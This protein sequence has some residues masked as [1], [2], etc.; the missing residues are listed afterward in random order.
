MF[1]DDPARPLAAAARAAAAGYEAVFAPDHLF[2]PGRPDRPSLEPFSVLAAVAA[3]HPTLRVGTLVT[4]AS[5]RP[6]GLLAK[7]GAALDHLSAG[8]AILGI[9]AGDSTSKAEHGAFGIPFRPA[10]ERVALMEETVEALRALF[11][12]ATWGGGLHVP[13]LLGPL[14]PPGDPEL[15]IG[16]RSEPVLAAAARRADAWN[17]W[18]MDAEGFRAAASTVRALADGRDVAATWGGILLVGEDPSDLDRL[19]SGRASRGLSM[20]LWQGTTDELRTFA[21]HLRDAG[22]DWM[23]VQPVGGD[24]RIELV[25]TSLR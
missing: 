20:D 18:A 21:A 14:L 16:G 15:W 22:A 9:G 8:R 23:I 25:A 1:T 5:I 17:G 19:R 3:R 2:P 4:R 10:L 12:G 13:P 11:A 7:Q 6:A 24:D